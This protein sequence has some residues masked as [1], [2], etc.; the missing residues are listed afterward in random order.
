[1]AAAPLISAQRTRRFAVDPDGMLRVDGARR[2]PIGSYQLPHVPEPRQALRE[3]GFDLI[4]TD[5]DPHQL[6]LSHANGLFAWVTLGSIAQSESHIRE[7]VA[8]LKDAPAL[9]FWETVDEPTFVWK[10]PEQI[11]VSAAE[12]A[13]TR[14]FVRRLDPDH[15]FYLNHAPTNLVSTLR[16]Y[17]AAGDIIATDI[18]PVIPRGIPELYAL[19][20]DGQQGDFTDATIGQVGRYTDKMRAVAGPSMPVFL[21]LQAFAWE[22]LRERDRDPAM[23]LYPTRAETRFMAYQAIVHGANGLLYYGLGPRTA[24]AFWDELRAVTGE[25][26]RLRVA[27][28]GRTLDL[29]L[30]IEYHDTGHSLDRGIEYRMKQAERGA[31][32][33]SVNADRNPVEASIGG[34]ARFR[35]CKPLLEASNSTFRNGYL[36]DRFSSFGVHLYLLT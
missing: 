21:V 12:L 26:A 3:A 5:P 15:L 33:I 25:L 24:P 28:A 22:E 29:K 1:M 19:W 14:E 6:A 30:P 18:Y 35:A 9:L 11:R 31:L 16:Q 20:P 17:N 36:R 7:I 4:H 34:L 23:A 13:A 27:L 10:K 2:F 32:L 8:Q